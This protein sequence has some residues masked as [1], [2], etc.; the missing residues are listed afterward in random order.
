LAT[1]GAKAVFMATLCGVP[2]LV[3]IAAGVAPVPFTVIKSG[4]A[5][6]LVSLMFTVV[7]RSPAPEGAKVERKLQLLPAPLGASTVPTWQSVASCGVT[8]AKSLEPLVKRLVIVPEPGPLLVT[9]EVSMALVVPTAR[10]VKFNGLGFAT[11]DAVPAAAVPVPSKTVDGL[12]TAPVA[13]IVKVAWRAPVAVGVNSPCKLHDAF[14]ARTVAGGGGVPLW[15]SVQSP[16]CCPP[17]KSSTSPAVVLIFEIVTDP[18]PLFVRV[19]KLGAL[20]V[21][22]VALP[23]FAG[24]GSSVSVAVPTDVKLRWKFVVPPSAMTDDTMK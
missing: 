15:P 2:L 1:R 19:T 17:M 14:T 22:T 18:G 21:P 12:F 20:A 8:T 3:A 16:A 5:G 10:S 13:V 7:E 6:K 4:V 9:T 24:L 23:K 11:T